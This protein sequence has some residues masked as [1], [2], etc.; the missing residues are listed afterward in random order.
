MNDKIILDNCKVIPFGP[1][2]MLAL[3]VKNLKIRNYSCFPM[4]C[5]ILNLIKNMY[6]KALCA[7][8]IF[9][10][11]TILLFHKEEF[12]SSRFVWWTI[13]KQYFR[14]FNWFFQTDTVKPGSSLATLKEFSDKCSNWDRYQNYVNHHKIMLFGGLDILGI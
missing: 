9:Q 5:W 10:V 11:T 3:T 2:D 12:K 6:K 13:R 14:N 1:Q 4:R 7:S 8:K